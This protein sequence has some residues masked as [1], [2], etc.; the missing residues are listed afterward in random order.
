MSGPVPK[1]S[2]PVNLPEPGPADIMDSSY[3]HPISQED[4]NHVP[5]AQFNDQSWVEEGSL[6]A[7]IP[8]DQQAIDERAS[9]VP[10][11]DLAQSPTDS[12]RPRPVSSSEDITV[13]F[14]YGI[15]YQ[16]QK[17]EDSQETDSKSSARASVS[18]VSCK[19]ETVV[20]EHCTIAHYDSIRSTDG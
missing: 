5:E 16:K 18:V 8:P 19:C 13:G 12:S 11:K 2:E 17:Q 15:P 7:C 14:Q 6:G 9:N 4:C 3:E 1:A 10:L 20:P